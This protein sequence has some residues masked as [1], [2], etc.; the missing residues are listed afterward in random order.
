MRS[1]RLSLPW[2]PTVNNYWK[3]NRNGKTYLSKEARQYKQCVGLH[4]YQVK[5]HCCPYTTPVAVEIAAYPPDNRARD[6]DNLLKV[7]LDAL[8]DTGIVANDWLVSDLRIVR[9][10]VIVGGRVDVV[11]EP[12]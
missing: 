10:N 8:E 6:L 11:V 12:I 4:V 5:P 9:K 2:P 3:H 7:L 1:V